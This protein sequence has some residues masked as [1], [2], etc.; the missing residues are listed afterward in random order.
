M[1][2]LLVDFLSGI[3]RVLAA[4]CIVGGAVAGYIQAPTLEVEPWAG[5]LIGFAAGFLT[6]TVGA[7]LIACLILIE[8]HLRV[9]ADAQIVSQ[10][11][12]PVR[13]QPAEPSVDEA[14]LARA[15]RVAA[16]AKQYQNVTYDPAR[17]RII[18]PDAKAD[19]A[20]ILAETDTKPN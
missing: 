5:A 6:A 11:S 18:K 10:T 2:R 14:A 7:G 4:V 20:S 9:L 19:T 17:N 13:L 8:N 3:V 16:Y 12:A 1:L 15:E